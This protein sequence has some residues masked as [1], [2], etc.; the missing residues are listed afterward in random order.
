MSFEDAMKSVNLM[1]DRNYNKSL[2]PIGYSIVTQWKDEKG[3]DW[4]IINNPDKGFTYKQ[5]LSLNSGGWNWV[6]VNDPELYLY[7]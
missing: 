7:K 4:R 6:V 3:W 2:I 5:T 1:W